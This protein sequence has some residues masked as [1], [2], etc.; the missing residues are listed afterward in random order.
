MHGFFVKK[1]AALSR[2]QNIYSTHAINSKRFK[3]ATAAR[4][5]RKPA[6]RLIR[7]DKSTLIDIVYK[8]YLYTYTRFEFSTLWQNVLLRALA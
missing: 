1:K 6:W 4:M 2:I 3:A 7:R 8:S 5:S